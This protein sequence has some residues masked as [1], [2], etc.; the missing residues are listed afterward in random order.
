MAFPYGMK[1]LLL[2]SALIGVV[3]LTPAMAQTNAAPVA[4]T[5][6]S[7]VKAE[8]QIA[9]VGEVIAVLDETAVRQHRALEAFLQTHGMVDKV[10]PRDRLREFVALTLDWLTDAHA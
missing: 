2:L 4:G 1:Q 10:V 8:G 9:N 5:L 3:M 7:I 6:T